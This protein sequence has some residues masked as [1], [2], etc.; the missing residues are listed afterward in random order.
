[1]QLQ[2]CLWAAAL[3][4]GLSNAA[5]LDLPI[6]TDNSYNLVNLDIGTPP[7]SYRLWFDTGSATSWVADHICATECP[8]ITPYKRVGYNVQESSTGNETGLWGSI[9]YFGGSTSGP[10]TSDVVRVGKVSWKQSFIA[11][12]QTSWSN[13]PGD[14]FLG[15]AFNSIITGGADTVMKTV[16]SK[17]DMPRF[18]I[19]YDQSGGK[20]G[21]LTLGGS[22][23]SKYVDGKLTKVPIVAQNGVYDVWASIIN[24]ATGT[25]TK[26]GKKVK[27]ETSFNHGR[28]V[29]DTGAGRISLAKG[30]IEGVYESIGMN[31]TAIWN[32]EHI[33][34]C[35]EF[36]SSW[37]VSF[38]FGDGGKGQPAEVT[39][40]GDQLAVPGFANQEDACWPPFDE[41][42]SEDFSLI[43]KALL[44]HFYTVWDFGSKVESKYKPTLGFGKLKKGL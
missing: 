43:G 34:R 12:W 26:N 11:A 15:L 27:A 16:M 38:S 36:N 19:Y 30:A 14:G 24:S 18:G 4:T 23:E 33:P 2:H 31:W 10:V 29:F 6:I 13:I 28:V 9:E 1:M 37:S 42:D 17:L 8:N 20:N 25:T 41:S 3:A 35:S 44:S 40:T 39:L 21:L 7:K 22:K 32:G 5:V